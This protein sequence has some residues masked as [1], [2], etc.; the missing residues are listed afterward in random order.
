MNEKTFSGKSFDL[1]FLLKNTGLVKSTSDGFRSIEQGAVKV[2][3]HK[4]L[5]RN[6]KFGV[7]D[8]VLQVGKRRFIKVLVR[9]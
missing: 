3:G 1:I 8:Y 5:E 9:D 7:G 4:V 2:D 6:T